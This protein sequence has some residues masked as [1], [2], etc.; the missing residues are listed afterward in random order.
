M[1]EP[2]RGNADGAPT[3][4]RRVLNR[5]RRMAFAL[6]G[7]TSF[8][9]ITSVVTT[10][11]MVALTFDDDPDPRWTPRVLDV[12]RA[13]AAKATFFVVGENVER[14]PDVVQRMHDEGHAL[15]NHSHH[16]PSFAF[17]D[18]AAR[19]RELRACAATL[20]PYPQSRRLFRPPHLDQTLASRYDAWCLGYDVI[21][22]N[23]HA[24]DWEER[25][26][27]EMER[28]LNDT[29]GAGD[30]VLL[31]DALFDRRDRSRNA[32]IAALD[33]TLQR[34]G[35]RFSFVT[36]PKLLE[37][38]RPCRTMWLKRPKAPRAVD[39]ATVDG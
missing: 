13:H 22:C 12:L 37:A 24:H 10:K 20:R 11:P 15:G 39:P 6:L 2:C 18:R 14:H 16:H 30:I 28:D 19:R 3:L 34:H 29:L 4:P 27:E 7:R 1:A 26:S 32:M 5:A 17:I 25:S 38:G 35:R 8:G 23:R 33:A 36:V 21:A 9:T 31:H